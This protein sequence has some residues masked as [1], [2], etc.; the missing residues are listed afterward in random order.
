[1]F[2]SIPNARL[3]FFCKNSFLLAIYSYIW[4]MKRI[5]FYLYIALAIFFQNSLCAQEVGHKSGFKPAQYEFNF[6]FFQLSSKTLIFDYCLEDIFED[7]S[8][9]SERKKPSSGKISCYNSS[10]VAHNFSAHYLKKILPTKLFFS[11]LTSLF[12]FICVFRL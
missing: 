3:N 7:D 10:F 2:I 6:A 8:S 9:D 4:V 5:L 11:I 1:V 12:I